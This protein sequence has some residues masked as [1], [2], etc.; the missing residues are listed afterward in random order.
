MKTL[1]VPN[2]RDITRQLDKILAHQI[3]QSSPVIS[4]FL[5]FLVTETIAGR[6]QF[7]KEY[8]IAINVLSR[9]SSF[10]NSKDAIVRIH[11]GRLRRALHEYYLTDGAGDPIFITIPKGH[12]TPSFE[13][14]KNENSYHRNEGEHQTKTVVVVPFKST[15]QVEPALLICSLIDEEISA[16]L[17][18]FDDL[19]V[20]AYFSQEVMH[21]FEENIISGAESTGAQFIITGG[22]Q[23]YHPTIR[24]RI[25]LINALTGEIKWTNLIEEEVTSDTEALAD[26]IIHCITELMPQFVSHIR[27]S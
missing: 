3:F 13:E 10:D 16:Q 27:A 12:Y 11:A 15:P 20:V 4:N 6:D 2:Q 9:P 22:V 19:S 17:C 26:K 23:H 1:Y 24:V 8:S 7:I 25:N 18:A 14:R 21:K 5:E